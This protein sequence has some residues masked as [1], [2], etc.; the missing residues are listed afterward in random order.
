MRLVTVFAPR[1]G[2]GVLKPDAFVVFDQARVKKVNFRFF[3]PAARHIAVPRMHPKN[4]VQRLQNFHIAR[5]R[6]G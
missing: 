4:D 2:H 6:G 1:G 3:Q 5:D